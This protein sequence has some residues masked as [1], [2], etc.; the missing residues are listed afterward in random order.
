MEKFLYY[1]EMFVKKEDYKQT[2]PGST[3][4]ILDIIWDWVRVWAIPASIIIAW[5]VVIYCRQFGH[6]LSR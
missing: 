3:R 2:P 6:T 4:S 1:E 5:V